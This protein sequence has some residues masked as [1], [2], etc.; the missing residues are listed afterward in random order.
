MHLP[1][2]VWNMEKLTPLEA[3]R[4]GFHYFIKEEGEKTGNSRLISL[5]WVVVETT[6]S[7]Y[8]SSVGTCPMYLEEI[9]WVFRGSRCALPSG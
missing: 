8:D 9:S 6:R 1:T 7:Y 3:V 5:T 4:C 2:V